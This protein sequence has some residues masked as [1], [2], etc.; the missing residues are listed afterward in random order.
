MKFLLFLISMVYSLSANSLEIEH[1]ETDNGI[2]V[3]FIE[4]HDLPIV[5]LRLN[6][7]AGNSRDGDLPGLAK[8]ANGLLLEGAEKLSAQQIAQQFEQVGA[9]FSFESGLDMATTSLRSLSDRQKLESVIDLFAKVTALPVFPADALERDRRALLAS[10]AER[11][12]RAGSVAS[13]G[14]FRAL[15]QGHPY[16]FGSHGTRHGLETIKRVDLIEFHRRYYVGENA[17]LAIVGDLNL[18]EAKI[19]AEKISQYL[20]SGKMAEALPGPEVI[21]GSTI[22]LVFDTEQTQIKIGMPLLDYHD[23]DFYA[24]HLGNHILGG[25][26]GHSWL[27]QKIR[28]ERGLTY[29]VYSYPLALETAGPY[30]ISMQTRNHQAEEALNLLDETLADFIDTGPAQAELDHAKKHI[31]G[32]FALRLDSNRKLL[33]QLSMI[34]FYQL[35]LN[36]LDEYP[37]KI[38][39]VTLEDI[40]R[41]FRKRVRPEQMIRIIVGPAQREDE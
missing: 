21:D 33:R 13:D 6:F 38:N 26:G 27:M 20:R 2:L 40:R 19:Y 31:T 22:R 23:P 36:Y 17:S 9:R 28:E 15:Y 35:P 18:A 12:K 3:L 7:R 29:G 24:L 25:S 41:V 34:G 10:L 16:E 37:L 8:L 11:Q 14:F 39:A 30:Q 4:T 32:S 1:W 5:D